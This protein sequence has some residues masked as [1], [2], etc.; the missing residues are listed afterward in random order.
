MRPAGEAQGL[1][2]LPSVSVILSAEEHETSHTGHH[3]HRREP[4][5]GF[6]RLPERR[7]R[8]RAVAVGDTDVGAKSARAGRT[9]EY[10]SPRLDEP[11]VKL[12]QGLPRA[13]AEADGPGG[14][15]Q[16]SDGELQRPQGADSL[17]GSLGDGASLLLGHLVGEPDPAERQVQGHGCHRIKL[18]GGQGTLATLGEVDQGRLVVQGDEPVA[19]AAA[20]CPA[21]TI[22]VVREGIEFAESA[23]VVRRDGG[24]VRKGGGCSGKLTD[25]LD[26]VAGGCA[27]RRQR[28]V[29]CGRA[30]GLPLG[31]EK[32]VSTRGLSTASNRR[33]RQ[34]NSASTT[35]HGEGLGR[36]ATSPA[37]QRPSWR[38]LRG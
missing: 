19:G 10:G 6:H 8:H 22:P 25:G 18:E 34:P 38:R 2:P 31:G 9:G 26:G 32:D 20:R 7:G 5:E 13:D 4:A 3:L 37:S 1:E 23:P 24:R 30:P 29:C 17:A 11:V 36:V 15:G 14:P 28:N 16:R 35:L 33:T 12:Q 27:Q 21:G